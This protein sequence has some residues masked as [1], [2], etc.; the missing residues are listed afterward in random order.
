MPRLTRAVPT[1]AEVVGVA[2]DSE[3][4]EDKVNLAG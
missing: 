1:V 3:D 4:A 2:D